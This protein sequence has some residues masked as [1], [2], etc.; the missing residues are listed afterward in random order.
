MQLFH[1]KFSWTSIFAPLNLET[2]EAFSHF[3]NMKKEVAVNRSAA[4]RRSIPVAWRE[5]AVFGALWGA[6]EVTLGAFLSST[7]IPLT[8]VIMASF[9]II[10][11]TSGQMLIRRNWFPLRTALVC[12]G[13]R[14]LSPGGIIFG[15]MF[16]IILQGLIVSLVFI[17]FRNALVSGVVS[18]FAATLMS[19]LQ[20]LTVKLF[21]YGATLWEIYLNLIAKGEALFHLRAG[22]GWVVVGLLIVTIC[23][24]GVVAGYAGWRIG[25]AAL[26]RERQQAAAIE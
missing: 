23:S 11:L 14:S 21:V 2:I 26:K 17:V 24:L 22:Q 1:E 18:G 15:P 20:G 3:N 16:A 7:R 9:G 8:G 6:G 10:I 5:A 4:A 25:N 12:A 19:L 13:L